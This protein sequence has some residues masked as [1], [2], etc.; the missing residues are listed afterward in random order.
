MWLALIYLL[1]QL[2]TPAYSYTLDVS[3]TSTVSATVLTPYVNP[4]ILIS[5]TDEEAI[6]NPHEV[7]VWQ[8]PNSD[9]TT[10]SHYDFYLD[11]ELLATSIP[12]DLSETLEFYFYT[13]Y[14]IGN[15]FY[16]TPNQAMDQGWHT[17]SVTVHDIH[18]V[19]QS[20]ETWSFYLD[21]IDHFIWLRKVD[22]VT[23]DYDTRNPS[24]LPDLIDRVVYTY[25][26][27]SILHGQTEA[28]VNLNFYLFCPTTLSSCTDSNETIYTPLADWSYDLPSL[29]PNHYYFLIITATDAA[30]NDT[31]LAFYIIYDLDTPITSAPIRPT[32][33]PVTPPIDPSLPPIEPI[34]PPPTPG[35]PYPPEVDSP[36]PSLPIIPERPSP[37]IIVTPIP[38]LPLID[39]YIILILLIIGLPTHLALSTLE[40]RISMGHLLR[41]LR[42][43]LL[44]HLF[45]SRVY[46]TIPHSQLSIYDIDNTDTRYQA[47]ADKYGFFSH[48]VDSRT[49]RYLISHTSP[50]T[51]SIRVSIKTADYITSCLNPYQK[52]SYSH[53]QNL[54]KYIKPLPLALAIITSLYALYIFPNSY[55]FVYLYLSIQTAYNQYVA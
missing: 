19:S 11:G 46:Q 32:I 44:P 6:S 42:L 45:R 18:T 22:D 37:P 47:V 33:I 21:S 8:A 3:H 26:S 7:F 41:Y 51:A 50:F 14:R 43:L 54:A 34:I 15:L 39:P 2:A 4:P 40:H 29:I 24:S 53:L 5:P 25:K 10:L 1:I 35:L 13:V 36:I 20:S 23:Y 55:V 49:I 48:S 27:D 28:G 16:L 17:W 31:E 9:N 12:A 52:T 38:H 30:G